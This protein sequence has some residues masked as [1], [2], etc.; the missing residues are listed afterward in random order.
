MGCT[1][2]PASTSDLVTAGGSPLVVVVAAIE[3]VKKLDT[4]ASAITH[5][6]DRPVLP[7]L[8]FFNIKNPLFGASVLDGARQTVTS[9]FDASGNR[10]GLE[11]EALEN[12]RS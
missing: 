3:G 9:G 11:S 2:L 10:D 7:G 12:L 1:F 4:N 8:P 6:S 5:R